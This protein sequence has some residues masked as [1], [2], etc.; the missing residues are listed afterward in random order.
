VRTN[1]TGCVECST[2]HRQVLLNG[3]IA[4]WSRKSGSEP[5]WSRRCENCQ[6]AERSNAPPGRRL[7]DAGPIQLP[8]TGAF[9]LVVSGL[10][11]D[12]ARCSAALGT[13]RPQINRARLWR[14]PGRRHRNSGRSDEWQFNLTTAQEG[15]VLDIEEITKESQF[16]N[17][18]LRA[19]DGTAVIETSGDALRV[20]LGL[21]NSDA[22]VSGGI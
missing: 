1:L 5:Y 9:R 14:G 21:V 16:L 6:T 15:V 13:C 4:L 11:D 17:F 20:R 7:V 19:P 3:S 22:V 12:V 2:A 8:Q 18:T 10:G